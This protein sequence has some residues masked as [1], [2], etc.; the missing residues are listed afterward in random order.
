MLTFTVAAKMLSFSD[1]RSIGML[2]AGLNHI[3]L[4]DSGGLSSTTKMS[5]NDC[6]RVAQDRERWRSMTADLLTTVG[7]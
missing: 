2:L 5:Y 7:T 1:L 4:E 6:I 3:R